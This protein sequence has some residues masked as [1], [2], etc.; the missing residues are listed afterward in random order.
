MY[1]KEVNKIFKYTDNIKSSIMLTL[2]IS[3]IDYLNIPSQFIKK[4]LFLSILVFSVVFF[5][6]LFDF[7]AS[8]KYSLIVAK[9]INIIDKKVFM[10]IFSILIYS[11]YLFFDF[12]IYKIVMLSIFLLIFIVLL[13]YR[14]KYIKKLL[15]K[16]SK[17]NVN[18]YDLKEFLELDI[19]NLPDKKLILF[20]E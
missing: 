9:G 4:D 16:Q 10:G 6:I 14:L 15:L 12:K 17:N 3:V 20:N 11:I 1:F 2:L 13:I 7:L 18:T 19:N 8:K 5:L